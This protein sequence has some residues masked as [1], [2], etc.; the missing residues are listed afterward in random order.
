MLSLI[1]AGLAAVLA[2][3]RGAEVPA[4]RA[5]ATLKGLEGTWV[6]IMTGTASAGGLQRV[7]ATFAGDGTVLVTT[8]ACAWNR[9]PSP[10]QRSGLQTR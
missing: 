3:G 6:T 5:G 1:A 4:A 10:V 2:P 8:S 7:Q 9:P